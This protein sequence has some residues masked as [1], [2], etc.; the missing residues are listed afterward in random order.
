MYAMQKQWEGCTIE[1]GGYDN[2]EHPCCN[3]DGEM[4]RALGVSAP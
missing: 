3:G 4:P 1:E 2:R